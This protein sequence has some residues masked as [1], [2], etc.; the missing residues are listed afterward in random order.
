MPRHFH[1]Q[2]DTD[3]FKIGI[4]TMCSCTMSG[5]KHHFEDLKKGPT[6]KT[7]GGIGDSML[8]IAGT[9]TFV[10]NIM[11]DT[12]KACTVRIP[13]SLYVPEL[14]LPLLSP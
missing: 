13:N 5:N 2:F 10:F 14:M 3:S 6:P 8:K 4:D 9:G 11:D 7:V 1:G 12:G